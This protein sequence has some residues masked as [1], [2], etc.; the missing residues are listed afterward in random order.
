M[1]GRSILAVLTYIVGLV[2][3]V[4]WSVHGFLT[5]APREDWAI[6]IVLPLAWGSSYWPM[7]GSL[8][9]IARVRG[10]QR[11]L[12]GV[13]AELGA[14]IDPSPEKLLELEEV[15]TKL[16]ARENRL[17]EFIVRPI[18]RRVL[19]RVVSEVLKR[20]EIESGRENPGNE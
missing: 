12:E 4:V 10:L 18:F 9:M 5:G 8:V 2:A 20:R 19:G 1:L 3:L 17:P 11:T 16:A 15:G 13:A 6:M 7:L 14:G